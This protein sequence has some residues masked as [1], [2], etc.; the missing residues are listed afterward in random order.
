MDILT[1]IRGDELDVDKKSYEMK[2]KRW[3]VVFQFHQF[4]TKRN[5]GMLFRMG[6]IFLLHDF[7]FSWVLRIEFAVWKVLLFFP[8]SPEEKSRK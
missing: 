8:L 5:A 6:L 4:H 2:S 7:I 1:G 3:L